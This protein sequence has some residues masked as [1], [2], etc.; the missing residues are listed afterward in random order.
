[1]I[2]DEKGVARRACGS[3]VNID[4]ERQG[5]AD[6]ARARQILAE[7]FESDVLGIVGEVAAAASQLEKDAAVMS[8]ATA[9][10]SDRSAGAANASGE[11][12]GNVQSVSAATDEFNASIREI[13]HQVTRSSQA[14]ASA[15]TGGR[16]CKAGRA[17]PCR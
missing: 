1:V 7:R 17:R 14:T 16:R 2:K 4:A 3:L 8:G 13:T 6:L 15:N 11:A 10:T 9:E 5:A 12:S